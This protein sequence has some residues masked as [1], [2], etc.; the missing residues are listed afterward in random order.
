[1]A[2][3]ISSEPTGTL[4]ARLPEACL[5]VLWARVGLP[6]AP[7][8]WPQALLCT[9]QHWL[10]CFPHCWPREDGLP[11]V[12]SCVQPPHCLA[13]RKQQKAWQSLGF[14]LTMGRK[15]LWA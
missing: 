8:P 7:S 2:G 1:M 3:L 10:L 5:S 12:K 4:P 14:T 13:S 6:V 9:V 15:W 11:N